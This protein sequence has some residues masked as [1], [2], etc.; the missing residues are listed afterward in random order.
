MQL[1]EDN[2]LD[3]TQGL[4]LVKQHNVLRKKRS[5]PLSLQIYEGKTQAWFTFCALK[6]KELISLSK[7]C[8]SIY[9][10]CSIKKTPL[11]ISCKSRVKS[12]DWDSTVNIMQSRLVSA[13]FCML[14]PLWDL[15]PSMSPN[16]ANANISGRRRATRATCGRPPIFFLSAIWDCLNFLRSNY[17]RAILLIKYSWEL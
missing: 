10:L 2:V 13:I 11:L 8:K 4:W 15:L 3:L 12:H 5:C 14:E 7:Y 16:T 9:I 1:V 6:L 17:S